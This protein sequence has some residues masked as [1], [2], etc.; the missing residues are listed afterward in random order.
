MPKFSYTAHDVNGAEKNGTLSA[1]D[2]PTAISQ[3]RSKG[4]FPKDVMVTSE[5]GHSQRATKR[6]GLS[7]QL[8]LPALLS[9]IR[10]KQLMIF[11]RQLATLINA[12]L[13]LLRGLKM[14]ERQEQNPALKKATTNI[15]ASIESGSTFADALAQHPRVFNRLYIN[16]VRAGEAGGVLGIVLE[17]LAEYMEKAQKIKNKIIAS[18]TYPVIIMIV[19]AS[20]VFLL[21]KLIVPKFEQIFADML[22]GQALPPL[23]VFVM[24]I[25][26][27]IE[28]NLM[29]MLVAIGCL[30]LL[31][32]ALRMFRMGRLVRDTYRLNFSPLR[33]LTQMNVLARFARTLGTLLESGVP[34]LQALMIVK[35]TLNNELVAS[36]VQQVHDQI[37]EGES[38]A[39]PI[40]ANPLFPPIF[41]GMIEVGEET[42]ELSAMLIK[43]ADMYEDEVDNT[44]AALSSII[45]PLLIVMLA[46]VIGTIVVALFLPMI[47]IIGQQF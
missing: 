36:A 6:A 19:S 1:S 40:E 14:L 38:M 27:S 12:G 10:P 39:A 28:K 13:P 43:I 7:T 2:R 22:G 24:N 30:I 34:I 32:I 37:K 5:T 31:S 35:E 26:A 20:I 46:L 47:S 18:M 16:M 29:T 4:L 15:N 17:R 3:L 44:V 42:G 11:T 21:M 45:E 25:S 33:K 41:G 8:T 9:I 23:T